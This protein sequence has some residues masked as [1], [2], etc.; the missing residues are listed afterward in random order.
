MTAHQTKQPP[1][2]TTPDPLPPEIEARLKRDLREG[3]SLLLAASADLDDRGN[4]GTRW[5]AAT[6]RRVMVIDA[7]GNRYDIPDAAEL[8][9]ASLH[10][11]ERYL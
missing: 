1:G 3:E 7:D 9:P 5:F 4:Y 2:V 6:D 11:L 8:D 10:R